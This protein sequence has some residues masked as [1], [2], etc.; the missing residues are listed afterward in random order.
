MIFE[1]YK[2]CFNSPELVSHYED[3]KQLC[4]ADAMVSQ[5]EIPPI[6]IE[7]VGRQN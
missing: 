3:E 4:V 6:N 1:G 7:N 5:K 2:K